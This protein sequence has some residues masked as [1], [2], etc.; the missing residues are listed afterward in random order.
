MFD[1]DYAIQKIISDSG[2][3]E[4]QARSFVRMVVDAQVDLATKKDLKDLEL[5]LKSEIADVKNTVAMLEK[6]TSLQF[7][8]LYVLLFAIG[9]GVAK[10]VFFP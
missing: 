1:T 2:V 5:S 8:G 4:Q 10:L 3:P 9:G 7:K 6:T